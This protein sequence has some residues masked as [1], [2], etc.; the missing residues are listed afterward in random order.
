LLSNGTT[1]LKENLMSESDQNVLEKFVGFFRE[2]NLLQGRFLA[3]V[4]GG[5]DSVVLCELCKQAGIRFSIAHCNFQLRGAES[6][7]DE[8]FVRSL[9][10]KYKVEIFVKKFDTHSYAE[11]K[12]ISIQE[13]ARELRYDW[14]VQL[15]QENNFSFTLLAHHKDDNT[16]TL[17]M[18]FFRGTGLQ[19]L[20][21]MP[22]ENRSEKFFLRPTLDVRRKEIVEFAKQHRLKWVEDSSNAESKYTRNFFRNELLPAIRKVYPQVEENLSGTIERFKKINALYQISVAELKKKVCE[23]YVSEVR[24]PVLKLMKYRHTSL[25][26]EIIK[27]YG[28]GEKQVD[29]VVKLAD[30][31][32]GRFIENEQYQIIRHRNWFIIAPKAGIADTIVIEAGME[33]VRFHGGRLELKS[34]PKEKFHLQR[35]ETIAQ[36]DAKHI[37]YPLLLRKWKQGDYF[38]PLGMHKKKKLARFFIDQKLPKNQKENVW[39]LESRKKIVWVVGMR[40]DDRF[41][42]SDST[43]EILSV[44][45]TSL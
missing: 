25:I 20:T 15:K 1:V 7:R 8:Q 6:E 32:S 43:K 3:A 30:A 28:F 45:V 16:E 9:G 44:S 27:D 18:N 11:E 36:L 39:V 12:K 34:I 17:L 26:Y 5:V 4:S 38:Y 35:K 31:D 37:E 33:Q 2:R 19:G 13:A 29:E 10:E 23:H 22:E 24:I 41:K 42:V 40:I 14:F 21:A